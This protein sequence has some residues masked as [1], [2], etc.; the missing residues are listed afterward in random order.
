MRGESREMVMRDEREESERE[1]SK[2]DEIK[3]DER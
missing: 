3:R 2:R 1:E